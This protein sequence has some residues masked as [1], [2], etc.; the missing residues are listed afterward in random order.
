MRRRQPTQKSRQTAAPAR[1][2]PETNDGGG[3]RRE[4]QAA[5]RTADHGVG[6]RTTLAKADQPVKW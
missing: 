1:L 3:Q 2:Q 5:R 6:I 4:R